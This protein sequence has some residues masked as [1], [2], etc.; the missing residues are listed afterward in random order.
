MN[1]ICDECLRECSK[2][3][4]IC[5]VTLDEGYCRNCGCAMSEEAKIKETLEAQ[6]GKQY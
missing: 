3:G 5:C 2:S 6:E 4:C 1:K